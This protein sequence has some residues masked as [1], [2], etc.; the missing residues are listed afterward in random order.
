MTEKRLQQLADIV[1]DIF[2]AALEV[3]REYSYGISEGIYEEALC[4]ELDNYGY[5]KE[6]QCDLPVYYK[7]QLLE[8]RF[9]M[10]IVIENDVIIEL[11]AV[12]KIL[13]EHRAQLFNYLR[14]TKKPIGILLN[15]GKRV[16]AERYFY[17][18]ETNDVT[19]FNVKSSRQRN[20]LD[21]ENEF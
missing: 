3:H 18:L 10:D 7:G 2:S 1:Y 17:D 13:P 11:K 12:E 8:K 14:L 5:E 9:R 21:D 16:T 4:L 6:S 20:Y 15:F 19:F